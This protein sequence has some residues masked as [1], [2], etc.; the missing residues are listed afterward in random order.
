M[1]WRDYEEENQ[2]GD[3]EESYSLLS[4]IQNLSRAFFLNRCMYLARWHDHKITSEVG[5]NLVLSTGVGEDSKL[6]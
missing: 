3:E 1:R 5:Y 2:T 6:G 4:P